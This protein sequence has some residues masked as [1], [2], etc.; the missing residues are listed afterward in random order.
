MVEARLYAIVLRLTAIRRGAVPANH[1]DQ[2]RAALFDLLRQGDLNFAT[3]VHNAN[4]HKPYTISLLH[5]A[6]R[7]RD[8][9]LHFG[10]GDPAEWRFTLLSEPTFEAVLRRYILNRSLPH[11]RI[12]AVEFAITDAFAA[13][14]SHPRSGYTTLAAL[15]ERWNQ[16]PE[17]LAR[18]LT[19]EFL[20]PTVFSHG[21]DKLTGEYRYKV[22]PQPRELF[23][24]LRKR[25]LGLGGSAPGD[26]FDQ[27]VESAID[28]HPIRLETVRTVVE[29]RTVPAFIG[30]VRYIHRGDARWLGMM[31]LL[32]DFAFWA[33]IGYQTTRGMGQVQRLIDD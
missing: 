4:A 30:R 20:A 5:G 23:S 15:T 8:G 24:N 21:K 6:K 28:L 31:H 12:G 27:W 14:G 13:N 16:P 32:A 17:T 33:G 29:R 2:A 18:Q 10:E 19:I 22:V 9:A 1:G 7:G 25:W 26:E 3:Q 11:V